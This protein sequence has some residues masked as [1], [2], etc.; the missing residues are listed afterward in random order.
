MKGTK[1]EGVSPKKSSWEE[2][3]ELA[4][5]RKKKKKKDELDSVQGSYSR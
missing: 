2:L 3:Q 4:K 1:K 5:K